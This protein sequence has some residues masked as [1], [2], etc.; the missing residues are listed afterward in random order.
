MNA[1][2][3]VLAI[4]A[5]GLGLAYLVIRWT[6]KSAA[7]VESQAV[8]AVAGRITGTI[9]LLSIKANLLG[10][11][12]IRATVETKDGQLHRVTLNGALANLAIAILAPQ[13]VYAEMM[14]HAD[15]DVGDDGSV[16]GLEFSTV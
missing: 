9:R 3:V 10:V 15:V 12:A 4:I 8:D 2:L 5:V 14:M 16:I 7:K 13:S 6:R 1:L 11:Q